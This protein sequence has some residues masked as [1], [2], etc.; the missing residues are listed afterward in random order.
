MIPVMATCGIKVLRAIRLIRILLNASVWVE[1]FAKAF[2][3]A[4]PLLATLGI[5]AALFLFMWGV[6]GMASPFHSPLPPCQCIATTPSPLIYIIN[7]VA[8]PSRR[9]PTLLRSA[10]IDP[11]DR[12]R[13]RAKLREFL[14]CFIL[15]GTHDPVEGVGRD[16]VRLRGAHDVGSTAV[17][18]R[19]S[20]GDAARVA[21]TRS[22]LSCGRSAL[23][24]A[25]RQGLPPCRC[26]CVCGYP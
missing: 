23:G 22:Y 11:Q 1:L 10:S 9:C 20:P 25:P 12:R 8:V 16:H 24:D 3:K 6:L 21:R 26:V 14:L 15:A 13:L 18:Y 5:V 4:L 2:A 7:I 17:F 19:V